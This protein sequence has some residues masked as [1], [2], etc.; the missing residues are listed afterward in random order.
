ML[1]HSS[2]AVSGLP[3]GE[4]HSLGKL[5]SEANLTL[6]LLKWFQGKPE[7]SPK[8]SAS[9]LMA[10]RSFP[11]PLFPHIVI[12]RGQLLTWSPM[13][14]PCA[15]PRVFFCSPLMGTLSLLGSHLS[16]G[17][18]LNT[19]VT[20]KETRDPGR[21]SYEAEVAGSSMKSEC[22]GIPLT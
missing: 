21:T 17:P 18:L 22:E 14:L 1:S 19:T 11:H 16:S 10:S 3:G 6:P 2:Q 15:P 4:A 8:C 9:P 5:V 20:E 7:L 12:Q 13:C